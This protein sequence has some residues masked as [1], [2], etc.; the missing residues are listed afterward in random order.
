MIDNDLSMARQQA[1]LKQHGYA[2][3]ASVE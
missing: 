1:L 3:N 2:V